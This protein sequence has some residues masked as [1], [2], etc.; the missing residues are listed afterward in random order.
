MHDIVDLERQGIPGVFVATVEF[1]DAAEAQAKSLGAEF[2]AVFVEHPIQDRTDEEMR[3]I[4]DEAVEGLLS[5][6]RSS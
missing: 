5:R 6:L 3:T 2:D 4:A 1:I